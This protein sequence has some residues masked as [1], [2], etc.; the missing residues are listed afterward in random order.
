MRCSTVIR[1]MT[2]GLC[3]GPVHPAEMEPATMASPL[4]AALLAPGLPWRPAAGDA[5]IP[6]MGGPVP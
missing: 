6:S 4:T 3:P 1:G 5:A 2:G